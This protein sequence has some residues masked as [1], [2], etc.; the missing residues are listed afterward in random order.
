MDDTPTRTEEPVDPET[1][2]ASTTAFSLVADE[3]R[4]EILVTLVTETSGRGGDASLSFSELRHAV[5]VDDSGRFNYHLDSLT[6]TF[7]READDGQYAATWIGAQLAGRVAAGAFADDTVSVE[8][9]VAPSCPDCDRESE[10]DY[11][12][13]VLS[14]D[15]P[16]HGTV[17]GVPAPPTA[18]R[19][20]DA[21]ELFRRL[22][23]T[24][25]RRVES[26]RSGTCPVCGA[27]V[28]TRL[29]PDPPSDTDRYTGI[30]WATYDCRGCWLDG[31]TP[32]Q[33]LCPGHPAARVLCLTAGYAASGFAVSSGR[34][35][36]AVDTDTT[37]RDPPRAEVTFTADD[38]CVT[39]GLDERLNTVGD[40]TPSPVSE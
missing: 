3:T 4:L 36:L 1:L 25:A 12:G 8:A 24:I 37:A 32:V 16:D 10:L 33:E 18:V 17:A 34:D 23:D 30:P 13:T 27:P 2:A 35:G 14:V 20:R 21:D 39:V 19:G 38:L 7:V 28:T 31:T 29:S 11:D 5:G 15:C 6:G 40:P 26:I 22:R 9:S